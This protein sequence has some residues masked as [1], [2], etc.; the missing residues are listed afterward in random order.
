[1]VGDIFYITGSTSIPVSNIEIGTPVTFEV[2]NS[3]TSNYKFGLQT[4]ENEYGLYVDTSLPRRQ[5]GSLSFQNGI[6][7]SPTPSNYLGIEVTP[8]GGQIIYIST[9][10]ISGSTL[11]LKAEE[12]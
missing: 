4:I 6:S 10:Y 1:M 7:L 3:L 11:Y 8:E 2:T 5:L 9:T 12:L